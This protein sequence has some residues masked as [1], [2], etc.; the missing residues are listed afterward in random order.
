[1]F[2]I[3]GLCKHQLHSNAH[4]NAL[5]NSFSGKARNCV[6]RNLTSNGMRKLLINIC[7]RFSTNGQRILK[8]LPVFVLA[9]TGETF[10]QMITNRQ[11]E[12]QRSII[13]EVASSN[14]F[15][16]LYKYCKQ[17]GLLKNSF[18]YLHPE[19]G[20]N[21][22][23]LEYASTESASEALASGSYYNNSGEKAS[24]PVKSR[25]LWLRAIKNEEDSVKKSNEMKL[26]VDNDIKL[27]EPKLRV[28]LQQANSISDQM[29]LLHKHTRLNELAMRLRFIAALQMEEMFSGIFL[30]PKVYPFGS[31]VNGFGKLG[32]D[33][34][35]ILRMNIDDFKA[36]ENNLKRLF[37]CEMECDD[38]Q[39]Q[40]KAAA[41][42]V[43]NFLPGTSR[44]FAVPRARIPI[45]KYNQTFLDLQV[46]LSL[47]NM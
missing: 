35:L 38:R 33:L 44:V 45:I 42:I 12:A 15:D 22:I 43:E 10:E 17:F 7:I 18:H 34:D 36:D 14:S 37:Y 19:N 21:F 41:A 24:S 1:M 13:V 28:A 11:L 6:Y 16:K 5:I 27:N 4:G 20:S 2:R 40:I 25:F 23:L 9:T 26:I 46:D 47:T 39:K 29:H 32:S 8:I 31:S 30:K 3:V